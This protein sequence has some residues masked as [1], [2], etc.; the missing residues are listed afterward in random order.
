MSE[1]FLRLC[2]IGALGA[3]LGICVEPAV[4]QRM[5]GASRQSGW[6]AK[7]PTETEGVPQSSANRPKTRTTATAT[8]P[9]P[10]AWQ[11]ALDRAGFSPG[12]ID[13][14]TGAKTTEAIRAFQAFAGLPVTGKPDAATR[15]ALGIETVNATQKIT[16]SAE[17]VG[18]I[19]PPPKDW[20]AR[21][22]MRFLGYR[23][24]AD[25]AAERG[26]CRIDL[27][28][29]LN[30][31]VE[32][33]KLTAGDTLVI[34]N[35]QK[36]PVRLKAT[37]V[38]IDLGA[39]IVRAHDSAGR[40]LGLFHCSIARERSK[41][42]TTPCRVKNIV[43]NPVYLF[44]PAGWPEVKDVHE[45][46]NIP[47]GPRGPVGLCWIGLT[48]PGYGIHGTP[49]PALIGKTGSHGC[50]RLTNW[51]AVRLASMLSVGTEVRFVHGTATDA[52]NGATMS[53]GAVETATGF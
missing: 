6:K 46:L 38:G 21:S 8:V 33:E 3:I 16:L 31:G 28:K 2:G 25:M 44:D 23:S 24:A 43:M 22:R 35:V 5:L 1:W 52:D 20:V 30:P 7:P 10:V 47:P 53:V 42:P 26:H 36:P 40:T 15:E 48:L 29:R 4:G 37:T 39:K 14:I 13:G 18:L 11:A 27:L 41:R 51:D 19:A 32:L 12:I 34:P 49:D 45:R 9:N 50:F 17:D